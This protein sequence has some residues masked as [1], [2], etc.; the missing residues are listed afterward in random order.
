MRRF[1]KSP[2]FFFGLVFFGL[3]LFLTIFLLQ[4]E[5]LHFSFLKESVLAETHY[6]KSNSDLNFETPELNIINENSLIANSPL[7]IVS[8]KVLGTLGDFNEPAE[9]SKEI[10]E[11]I[12]EKGDTIQSIAK[13][14]NISVET[15][16]WANDLSK[17][18][19]ITAGQELIILPVSGVL[20]TVKKGDTLSEIA[21]NYKAKLNEIVAFNELE[22]QDDIFQGDI[23]IIPGGKMPPVSSQTPLI[24]I[25]D[26]YFIYPCEGIISQGLHLFNAIDIANE[27]GSLVIAP[28]GGTVLKVKSG[29]NMGAGNYLTIL[30]LNG[31]ITV[32]YHLSIIRVEPGQKVNSGEIIGFMGNTG[33]TTGC[34]LH[35]EVRN[36]QNFLSKYPVG[37]LLK[38]GAK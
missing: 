33:R 30:H 38:W 12:V 28:A 13:K 14:F 15:L 7:W 24:P 34:H 11:Y 22:N 9:I 10:I 5:A 6:L 4:K 27:C 21:K 36:A 26:S 2:F 16:L 29:W 32:Y 23:L 8:P 37:T 17:N 35:F 31:V 25:A 3:A 1:I 18:S 20:Y 19:K